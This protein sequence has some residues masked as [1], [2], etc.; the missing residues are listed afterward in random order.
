MRVKFEI[1]RT[2]AIQWAQIVNG[3]QYEKIENCLH[4]PLT[5]AKIGVE[6]ISKNS[7]FSLSYVEL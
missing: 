7:I 3:K 1:Q 2:E 5:H 6:I 4:G